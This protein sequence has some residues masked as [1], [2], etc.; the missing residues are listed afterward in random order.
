VIALDQGGYK[1]T[2]IADKTGI[3]FEK[4]QVESLQSA[5]NKFET[6]SI[7]IEDLKKNAAKFAKENFK[8]QILDLIEK[9]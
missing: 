2:I 3:F 4:L 1:E 7:K 8:K 9:I 6:T 5:I